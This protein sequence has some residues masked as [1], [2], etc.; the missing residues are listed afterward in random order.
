MEFAIA[1]HKDADRSYGVTV[2]SL[3]GAFSAGDTFD[4]AL[5]NAKEAILSH[6]EVTLEMGQKVT[7]DSTGVDELKADPDYEGAMWAVVDVDLSALE[8]R[9]EHIDADAPRFAVHK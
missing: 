9:A 2:P 7:I 8:A 6:I 3:P 5:A 4:E 1:L